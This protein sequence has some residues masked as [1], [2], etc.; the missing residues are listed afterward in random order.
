[1]TRKQI[2]KLRPKF[3][4]GGPPMVDWFEIREGAGFFSLRS[5]LNHADGV[6]KS[7]YYFEYSVGGKNAEKKVMERFN[8]WW[9]SLEKPII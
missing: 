4:F 2:L 8:N 7:P 5:G 1:M 6:T 9:N 3:K